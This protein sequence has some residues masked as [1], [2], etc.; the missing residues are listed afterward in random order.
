MLNN[1][2]R[3]GLNLTSATIRRERDASKDD[4]IRIVFNK[5]VSNTR[6]IKICLRKKELINMLHSEG[7]GGINLEFATLI[8]FISHYHPL[9]K[10]CYEN[11]RNPANN[12][13]QLIF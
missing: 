9:I 10:I 8:L 1:R 12:S 2:G 5:I 7:G 3:G 13:C 11:N 4:N 6:K